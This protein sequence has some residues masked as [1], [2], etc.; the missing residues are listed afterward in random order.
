MQ[1]NGNIYRK[2]HPLRQTSFYISV[3]FASVNITFSGSEILILT[4]K[5]CINC[6]LLFFGLNNIY[7]EII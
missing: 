4:S 6:I 7:F 1:V 3:R 2:S 5:E